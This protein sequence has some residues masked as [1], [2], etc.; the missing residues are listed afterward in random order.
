[1]IPGREAL[2][3]FRLGQTPFDLLQRFSVRCA[4]LRIEQVESRSI[5]QPRGGIRSSLRDA[6]DLIRE[7]LGLIALRSPIAAYIHFAIEF[8]HSS[9]FR[10]SCAFR[11]SFE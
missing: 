2:G 11:K 6:L 3:R 5:V 1:M 7:Q 9:A 4:A 8:G 10:K